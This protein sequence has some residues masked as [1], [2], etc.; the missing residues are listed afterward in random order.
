MHLYLTQ[1]IHIERLRASPDSAEKLSTILSQILMRLVRRDRT[2]H[3][4]I[5]RHGVASNSLS[6]LSRY[7]KPVL[8]P[9]APLFYTSAYFPHVSRNFLHSKRILSTP[10]FRDMQPPVCLPLRLP[11]TFSSLCS[12]LSHPVDSASDPKSRPYQFFLEPHASHP[13]KFIS[14]DA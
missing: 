11:L 12:S 3:V 4:L 14:L 13:H 8:P 5:P 7:P 1:P 10:V 9:R 6:S 2:R